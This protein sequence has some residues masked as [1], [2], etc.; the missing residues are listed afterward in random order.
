MRHLDLKVTFLY[1]AM[2]STFSEHSYKKYV[3][4]LM[5]LLD[6]LVRLNVNQKARLE[7]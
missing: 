6:L 1:P 4:L 2:H 7:S 3:I 5:Y